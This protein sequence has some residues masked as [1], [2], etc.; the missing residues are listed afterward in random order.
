PG[1]LA[2]ERGGAGVPA[3]LEELLEAVLGRPPHDAVVGDV[4]EQQG[5]VLLVPDGPLGPLEPVGED[6]DRGVL[7]DELVDAGVLA[8][9]R[10]DGGVLLLGRGGGGERGRGEG[11]GGEGAEHRVVSWARRAGSGRGRPAAPG[12]SYPPGSKGQ[13][14]T[15]LGRAATV[16]SP[17]TRR[18]G[19]LTVAA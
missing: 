18:T 15:R 3:G 2:L 11:G 12:P 19:D 14:G 1:L 7:G 9:D 4:G 8:V 10:A 6:L 17:V 5:A 16:R 13:A